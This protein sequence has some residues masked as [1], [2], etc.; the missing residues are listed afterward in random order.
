MAEFY[1]VSHTDLSNLSELSLLSEN[2]I[3]FNNEIEDVFSK[4]EIKGK[5][6]ELYT[7]GISNHGL[8]YLCGRFP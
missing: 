6:S 7:S 8:Q 3:D 4:S 1:T 5:L 2:N